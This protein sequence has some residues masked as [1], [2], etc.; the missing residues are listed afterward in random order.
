MGANAL[1]LNQYFTERFEIKQV[2]ITT[3]QQNISKK[4]SL[5]KTKTKKGL[6]GWSSD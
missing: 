1:E 6:P 2:T 4:N 3:R 5:L